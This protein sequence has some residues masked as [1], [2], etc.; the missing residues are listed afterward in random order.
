ME[1]LSSKENL[2]FLERLPRQS[3]RYFVWVLW[4]ITWIGLLAGLFNLVF[5]EYVVLFS[6]LHALLFLVLLKFRVKEFPAQIRIVYLIWVVVGT[7]SWVVYRT[8]VFCYL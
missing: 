7:T 1:K 6:A 4:F 3:R 5:Y 8:R 2:T